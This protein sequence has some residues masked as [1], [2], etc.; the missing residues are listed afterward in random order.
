MKQYELIKNESLAVIFDAIE[1]WPECAK[2]CANSD[3]D[4]C[5]AHS[6]TDAFN[7]KARIKSEVAFQTILSVDDTTACYNISACFTFE[8]D[9]RQVATPCDWFNKT[10]VVSGGSYGQEDF[11]YDFTMPMCAHHHIESPTL[12]SCYSLTTVATFCGNSCPSNTSTV[13]TLDKAKSMYI[14]GVGHIL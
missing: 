8:F 14:Y 1:N 5:W 6:S 12:L 7:K 10:G 3:C 2:V 9:F 13:H 4:S 11:Y